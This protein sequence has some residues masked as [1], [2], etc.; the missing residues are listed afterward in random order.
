MEGKSSGNPT[1]KMEL[2]KSGEPLDPRH[3]LLETINKKE[4]S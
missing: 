1:V 4:K 3:W 2:K